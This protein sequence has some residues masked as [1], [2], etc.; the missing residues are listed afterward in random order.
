MMAINR[1]NTVQIVKYRFTKI[2]LISLIFDQN[3]VWDHIFTTN[4]CLV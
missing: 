3:N 4:G 2:Q 1:E